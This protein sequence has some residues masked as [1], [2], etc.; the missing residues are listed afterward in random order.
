VRNDGASYESVPSSFQDG[1]L[2]LPFVRIII[3]NGTHLLKMGLNEP[4]YDFIHWQQP[5]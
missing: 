3:G 5:S 2:T 1:F 4:L